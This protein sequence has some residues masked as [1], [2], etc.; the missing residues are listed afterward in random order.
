M[1]FK[2]V[3]SNVKNKR[4]TAIIDNMGTTKGKPLK[5]HFGSATGSTY[6][7]HGDEVK[8]TNY[9]KRHSKLNEDYT[10]V[11][12][13]SLSRYVL[14]GSSNNINNNIIEFKKKFNLN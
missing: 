13:A 10:K 7:D 4:Y 1:T 9:I 8:R 2:I 6:I 12:P 3:K 5:L 14:W 11:T